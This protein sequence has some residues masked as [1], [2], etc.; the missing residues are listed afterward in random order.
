MLYSL[1]NA[2][3]KAVADGSKSSL[4]TKAFYVAVLR[5]DP[6]NIEVVAPAGELQAIVAH[7]PGKRRQLLYGKVRPLAGE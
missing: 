7:L 4:L 6:A 1:L 3:S 5:E 2:A